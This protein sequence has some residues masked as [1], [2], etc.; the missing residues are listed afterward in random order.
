MLELGHFVNSIEGD[1]WPKPLPM[2]RSP[3]GEVASTFAEQQHLWM[4][5]FSQIEAGVMTSWEDLIKQHQSQAVEIHG[6]IEPDA[7]LT[8]LGHS[9]PGNQDRCAK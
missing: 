1:D 2:L 5:Q 9:G 7:F 8:A 3:S 6:D 4:T